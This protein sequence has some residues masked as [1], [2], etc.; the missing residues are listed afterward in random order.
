MDCLTY[1]SEFNLLLSRDSNQR[2]KEPLPHDVRYY[3]ALNLPTS[4]AMDGIA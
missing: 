1:L 2:A 3:P 4:G